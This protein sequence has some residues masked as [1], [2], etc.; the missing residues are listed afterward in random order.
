MIPYPYHVFMAM[1]KQKA[2][3]LKR[4]SSRGHMDMAAVAL[5][6]GCAS[7]I[8]IS[9]IAVCISKLRKVSRCWQLFAAR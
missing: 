8:P 6:R 3:Y 5:R 7:Y 2:P 4:I 1:H 9:H